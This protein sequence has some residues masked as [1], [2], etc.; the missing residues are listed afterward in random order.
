MSQNAEEPPALTLVSRPAEGPADGPDDNERR[1]V[2]LVGEHRPALLAYAIRL[3]RGDVGRAED[4]VQE[5][6]VR[7]WLRIDRLTPE[8]GS[9]GS[10]LRRVAYNLAV[11]GHRMRQVRP[12]EVELQQHDVPM[13]QDGGDGTEQIVVGM[14]IRDMLTSIWPEHRAV[15]EE[16]Y[17]RDR[18]VAEAAS[19][20]GIPVGT[21]KSRLFYALRT[22]RGTAAESGLR[23]S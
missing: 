11:D 7:A 22:L 9:V 20:L 15:V 18:T 8:Q 14:V 3:T 12:P 5:T 4:I 16:V 10:W 13:R 19:V 2:D 6:F 1:F 17:L 21:V 23:A